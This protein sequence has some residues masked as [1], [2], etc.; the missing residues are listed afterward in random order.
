M[1]TKLYVWV[2]ALALGPGVAGTMRAFAS[3]GMNRGGQD[4]DYSK[5]KRYQQGLRDGRDDLAHKRDH[6]RRRRF[7]KDEDQRA[8]EAGYQHGHE[9]DHHEEHE[10]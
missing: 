1:N 9:G 7:K 10:K 6:S 4:Q 8:Y 3:P 5:N 2:L